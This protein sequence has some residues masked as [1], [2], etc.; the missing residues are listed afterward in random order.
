MVV[1]MGFSLSIC[2]Y[3][4]LRIIHAQIK[5][6][7]KWDIER[8]L[9]ASSLFSSFGTPLM[10]PGTVFVYYRYMANLYQPSEFKHLVF[11][12]TD[13]LVVLTFLLCLYRMTLSIYEVLTW[14]NG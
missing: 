13:L 1:C 2:I 5:N 3:C 8:S 14:E 6:Y 12:V 11:L 4:I 9:M 10:N 7:K